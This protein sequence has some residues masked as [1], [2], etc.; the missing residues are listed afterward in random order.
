ALPTGYF[1]TYGGQFESQQAAT[2][3]I[4]LLGLLSLVGMILVLYSHFKSMTIVTQILVNI[5]LALVGSVAA[6]YLTGGVLSVATLVGFITLTGIAS[7]NTIMMISHYLHLL[8]EEGETFS[9][10]MVI[11]GSLERLVPVLMTALTA[12]LALIPLALTK[13][14]SGKEILYPVATVILGGLLSS[15]LLD[16]VVTPAIFYRFGRSA[17]ERYVASATEEEIM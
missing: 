9:K 2:R 8:K 11:R 5:P 17:S 12:G 4:G 3:K 13:G 6:I 1:V 7:R 16:M 10:E 14:E 15:T